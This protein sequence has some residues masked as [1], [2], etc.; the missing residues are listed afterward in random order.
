MATKN[1][2][3]EQVVRACVEQHSNGFNP[4]AETLL[5]QWTGEPLKVCQNAMQR[6]SRNGLI[7]YGVSLRTAWATPEGLQALTANA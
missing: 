3:D 7:D 6:A 1:I 4:D 2:T 5:M